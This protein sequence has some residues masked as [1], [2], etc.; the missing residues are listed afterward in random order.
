MTVDTPSVSL[1]IESLQC[2]V[3]EFDRFLELA[4]GDQRLCQVDSEHRGP[5][6]IFALAQVELEGVLAQ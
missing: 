4:E 2:D 5:R 3:D 1:L 6:I